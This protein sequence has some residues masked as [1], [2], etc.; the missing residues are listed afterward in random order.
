MSRRRLRSQKNLSRLVNIFLFFSSGFIVILTEQFRE[1]GRVGI[2]EER[3]S[4]PQE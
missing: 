1:T 4:L 2:E 3:G